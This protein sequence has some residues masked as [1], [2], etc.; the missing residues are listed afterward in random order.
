MASKE[1]FIQEA[2]VKIGEFKT[3]VEQFILENSEKAKAIKDKKKL[4]K[5]VDQIKDEHIKK[6]K[7]FRKLLTYLS[8]RA[9]EAK[10]EP[11]DPILDPVMNEYKIVDEMLTDPAAAEE[12]L[13]KR[14]TIEKEEGISELGPIENFESSKNK[15]QLEDELL[16]LGKKRE[17][18]I[19]AKEKEEIQ[20]KIDHL[21][22]L[23]KD[24][25]LKSGL[26]K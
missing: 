24:S 7:D 13:S 15:E 22:R 5:F 8:A 2:I 12:A 11:D 23:Y 4:S 19:S 17:E 6:I 26:K 14:K 10:I 9:Q 25:S 18:A 3:A 21:L 20:K 16:D 1:E